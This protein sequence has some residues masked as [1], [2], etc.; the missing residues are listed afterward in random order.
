MSLLA[1]T[2]RLVLRELELTDTELILRLVNEPSFLANIG[3]RGVRSLEDA[4]RYLEAGPLASYRQHGHGL[5]LVLLRES[6]RPIG[7]CGLLRRERLPAPDLGYAL[8][9]EYWH[10]G[11]ALEA[12]RAVLADGRERFGYRR[13]LAIVSPGN[14]PSIRVLERLG[15]TRVG[16]HEEPPGSSA[17]LLYEL[18]LQA[19]ES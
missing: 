8:L 16:E 17:A 6:G 19:G 1:E 2:S 13:L 10:Q 5:N 9:P 11:Y 14:D 4:R 12:C 3:D 18:E 7:I 15:F